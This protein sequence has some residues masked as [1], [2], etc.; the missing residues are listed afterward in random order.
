MSVEIVIRLKEKYIDEV[1]F[2]FFK[3]AE[4]FSLAAWIITLNQVLISN[5]H[6]AKYYYQF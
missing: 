6:A 4:K 1:V 3:I 2:I 5:C